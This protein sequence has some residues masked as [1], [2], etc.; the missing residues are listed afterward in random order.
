MPE[1]TGDTVALSEVTW[2]NILQS[3][4]G[5]CKLL[6]LAVRVRV[7]RDPGIGI[8]TL[9]WLSAGSALVLRPDDY[10]SVFYS[11][12]A[13]N[14]NV[15][16]LDPEKPTIVMLHPL[17]L[18]SSWMQPQLEDPRLHSSYNIVPTV[19]IICIFHLHTSFAAE[20]YSFTALRFAIL[21]PELCLSLTLCNVPPQTELRSVFEA[22]EELSQLWAYSEDL[23]SFESACKEVLTFFAGDA[24]ADIQDEM[25]AFW[26][27]HY[28]PFRRS[29]IIP[30][31][32]L[33]LNRTPLNAE[34]LA[35]VRCPTL[36]IQAERC[37]T[38]PMEYAQQLADALVNS[39]NG[40]TIFPVKATHAYLTVLSSSIV[41]QVLHKFL[42]RQPK[43][44]SDLR[45]PAIPL[46][47]RMK[48]ALGKLAEFKNDPSI[49]ERDPRTPISFSC[50]PDDVANSQL[51]LS[52]LFMKGQMNAFN[53]LGSDGRPL[54]KFSERKNDHW[55]DSG[56]DGFSYSGTKPFEKKKRPQKR[57]D[58]EELVLPPSEPVSQEI[59][60]VSR[61]RRT[62]LIPTA[63]IAD[64]QVI[65]GSMAKVVASSST[66]SL[67][68]LPRRLLPWQGA[69]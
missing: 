19:F 59:Q 64:K 21:F 30:N 13:P 68:Q 55:L 56:A 46:L 61:V 9:C 10:A 11:T 34:E 8:Q 49:A 2:S 12:N 37:Q 41:N 65:K 53:P 26:E 47:E 27:L 35:C 45:P 4:I 44:R 31:V 15:S 7:A 67:P 24:N 25:V 66:S 16:S 23:E 63:A 29:Y 54:R 69:I 6:T 22:V 51:E 33:E 32:N 5:A 20:I 52:V 18:D 1:V 60:Q 48:M 39:P 62:K 36:I 58:R 43:T 28:P 38:H 50:V 57:I 14:L 40:P 17:F 3:S 42:S